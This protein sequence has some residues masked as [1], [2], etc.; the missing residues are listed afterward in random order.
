MVKN[1]LCQCRR[2][3]ICR[4]DPWVRKILWR[5]EW[6]PTPL[7]LTGKF[8]GQRHLVGCNPWGHKE[9]DTT[10]RLSTK[11]TY[12]SNKAV[13]ARTKS[14]ALK[15]VLCRQIDTSYTILCVYSIF[16]FSR[17]I[18]NV[19]LDFNHTLRCCLKT[20]EEVCWIKTR[21]L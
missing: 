8:H 7:F 20:V 15:N 1:L 9:S 10:E 16:M 2:C 17:I 3:K 6:L 4:F 13:S 19:L 11:E 5:R 21:D 14:L 12:T 18:L